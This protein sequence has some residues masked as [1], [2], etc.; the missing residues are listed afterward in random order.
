MSDD[1][2]SLDQ[3]IQDVLAAHWAGQGD[4][5]GNFYLT[6][7]SIDAT[8]DACWFEA[9]T[10]DLS[11]RARFCL[12]EWASLTCRRDARAYIDAVSEDMDD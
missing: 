12:V 7:E 4:M 6:G 9:S 2:R 8:G 10:P 5:A 11:P 3:K 1:D